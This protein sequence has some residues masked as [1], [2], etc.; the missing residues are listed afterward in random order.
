[1]CVAEIT[2]VNNTKRRIMKKIVSKEMP[3]CDNCDKEESYMYSCAIC[4]IQYCHE[5]SK[6][7]YVK[8][9]AGVGRIRYC[10]VCHEKLLQNN[11]DPVFKAYRKINYLKNEGDRFYEDHTKRC[12]A[13]EAE[14]KKLIK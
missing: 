8:Y 5:C 13:A 2:R 9:S 7:R 11:N 12:D 1:M 14:L 6:D 3:F 4:G 10:N